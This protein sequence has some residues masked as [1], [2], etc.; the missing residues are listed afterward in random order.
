MR[1][2][3]PAAVLV[4]ALA[5]GCASLEAPF[6][7]HLG[8]DAPAVREC[9]E[10]YRT[11]DE[12][13]Q[14]AGVRDAQ[15]AR[16]PGFPYLRVSRLLAGLRPAAAADELAL[17]ALGERM[18]LLDLEAR[19][20]ELKNLPPEPAGAALRR[21]QECGR[22]LLEIDLARPAA[23]AA[24][25][26]RAE[27]PDDYLLAHRILGLYL[28]SRFAFAEGVRR[29]EEDTRAAFR[30]ER[31]RAPGA[32][33]VR[34]APASGRPL[35]RARA[36]AILQRAAH[37]PL[38]VPEPAESELQEL[39]AAHAPSF[40][41]EVR[42]EYDR[43]GALRWLRGEATPAVDGSQPVA[44]AHPAW[45]RYR[46]RVLLQ[47]V[48]TIWFPERPAQA[49]DDIYA[50][51]LDGITWRVTLAPDGE[52][53]LYDAMHP[54]G[55]FH[56]FFPTPRAQ[57]LP[58]PDSLEEWNFSP[59][60]LPRIAEGERP[61]LRLAS[62]THA[63]ERVSVARGGDSPVR[64]RI[65]PYGELRS[66]ARTDGVHASA[67]GPDG[68]VPGTERPERLLFWPMGIRS[69]GAMRVW[70]RQPTAFVGRRHFDDADLLE[71]R[72]ELDL[73]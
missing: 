45:T 49:A 67:F 68:L 6:G 36:A 38:G 1:L 41:I 32:S 34:H 25:L 50:G 12:R 13:V 64:Y 65:R 15:D 8:A 21:T 2:R 71:K 26:A 43:F 23:R 5:A 18:L 16:V 35:P 39:L 55:C 52:P 73:R 20:Y 7:A 29:Y 66:L 53:L 59:Q 4:A 47:L 56:M 72:F 57:P 19:R 9:A 51:K 24:L 42:G 3:A 63:I 44:Y 37:N 30:R 17:Q 48:Y 33:L 22:L 70:G 10:W 46:G 31:L 62:G 27:V 54:C 28:L 58:A 60:A 40:E 69:A 11:L 14:A 61:L